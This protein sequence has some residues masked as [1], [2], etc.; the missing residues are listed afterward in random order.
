MFGCQ[1]V[2]S[3]FW[4]FKSK[5]TSKAML[6]AP[7]PLYSLLFCSQDLNFV[8]SGYSPVPMSFRSLLRPLGQKS[9]LP[10]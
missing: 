8:I 7:W 1:G 3:G 2:V 9:L 4:T 6:N 10:D 5:S